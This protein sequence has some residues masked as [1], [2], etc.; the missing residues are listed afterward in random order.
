MAIIIIICFDH[1]S[2]SAYVSQLSVSVSRRRD[3]V[4]VLGGLQRWGISG[5]HVRI[6]RRSR[7]GLPLDGGKKSNENSFQVS[8]R[9][10][11]VIKKKSVVPTYSRLC[12]VIVSPRRR[13]EGLGLG[14]GWSPALRDL[15]M[16][17]QD[18]QKVQGW[19]T[20]GRGKKSNEKM[21]L[22]FGGM[23][24]CYQKEI[25]SPT[26]SRLC[27]VIEIESPEGVTGS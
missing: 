7:A 23:Q 13:K 6:T 12:V 17:R 27:V 2:A 15:W 22:G 8:G 19:L 25:C 24:K 16:T 1:T 3:W 10:K 5:W 18:H 21:F 9:N 4:L 11:N 20:T 26:Y 14:P